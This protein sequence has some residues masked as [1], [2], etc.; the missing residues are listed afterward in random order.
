MAIIS[1]TEAIVL[2]S[3]RY[4]ESSRIVSLYTR[5]F[6]KVKVV[7]KGIRRPKSK[8]GSSLEPFTASNIVFYKRETKDLYNIS[9]ADIVKERPELRANLRRMTT[10]Y[11]MVDFLDAANPEESENPRLYALADSMLDAVEELPPSTLN[12]LLWTFLIRAA[13]ILGYG[14]TFAACLRCNRRRPEMLFSPSLGGVVC[15][16]CSLGETDVWKVSR[17]SLD[18][19]GRLADEGE[20]DFSAEKPSFEQSEE[21]TRALRAHL[22]YHTERRMNSFDFKKSLETANRLSDPGAAPHL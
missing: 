5:K 13:G 14:P 16:D 10:A 2:R 18:L 4:R 22:L 19:L 15:R 20:K 17:A 8:F 3:M 7:A 9:E 6:G 21:I 1:K 11:V 12:L